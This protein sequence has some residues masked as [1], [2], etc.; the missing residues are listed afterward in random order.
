ME[1]VDRGSA[2]LK[3]KAIP[4]CGSRTYIIWHDEE[5]VLYC[6]GDRGHDGPHLANVTWRDK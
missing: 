1:S 2:V 6:I 4:V 3:K 5:M